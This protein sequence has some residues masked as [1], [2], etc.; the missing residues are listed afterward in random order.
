[1]ATLDGTLITGTTDDF[2]SDVIDKS[3][4]GTLVALEDANALSGATSPGTIL[5]G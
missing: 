3:K 2:H 4:P 1:M 5:F